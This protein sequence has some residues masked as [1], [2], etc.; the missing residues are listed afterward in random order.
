MIQKKILPVLI[1]FTLFFFSAL[2]AFSQKNTNNSSLIIPMSKIASGF[3]TPPDSMLLSVYWYWISDNIS[4][5]GVIKDLHAMKKEGINRAFIGNIGLSD[6][7]YGKVKIFSDEWWDIMH[8][9]LKTATELNIEIGIFNSPG[10]SQSGGP[11][12]KPDE[13]MRYLTSSRIEAT[14]PLKLDVQLKQAAKE[15][16]D[17]RV[18]AF[19][20]PKEF[21]K[22]I[23]DFNPVISSS[24][25]VLDIKNCMDGD[26]STEIIIPLKS[27]FIL[28]FK[29]IE[30]FTARSITFYPAHRKMKLKGEIQ[31]GENGNFKTIKS[32][33][34]DRSNDALNVGF[35]PYAPAAISIPETSSTM[36]R[37]VFKNVVPYRSGLT[38]INIS[39]SPR[40]EDYAE[41]TLAKMFPTPFPYWGSYEWPVQPD[42]HEKDLVIDPSKVIDISK[43]MNTDGKLKWNVPNGKWII[44]RTGM[45]PTGVHNSPASPEGTGLEVDKMSKKHVAAHFDAFLG[46]IMERIPAEDRKTWKVTVEDSYETGGQNWTDGMIEKFK[47]QF[48]YDPLPYIP[49]FSGLVVG[50][51]DRSDRFLWDLRRFVANE[52]AYQYVAGLREVSHQHGL[53]TWLENYGHW[54]FPSTFLMYG[55]QSDEVAGEFWSE[56]DLGNIENRAASSSAHIYGKRKVS[57]E[58]F[59]AG[60]KA[61]ARYPAVMKQRGD[62]FFTEGIN[63]TLLHLYIEQPYDDKLPGVNAPFGNEFNRNNTWFDDLDL[64]IKY[65]KRC[66]FMLQQGTYIADAAYFIGEDAPKM[67]GTRDPELPKGYSFDYMNAEVIE[68]RMQVKNGRLTL[69]DGMNYGILVLPKLKTMRPEVLKKIMQ[70]VNDGAVVL[71]PK[72]DRSPSLENYPDADKEVKKLAAELWGNID[73]KNIKVHHYGKGMVIDGMNM[74]EALSRIKVSPDYK[75]G[76][77]DSTLFIHR[78]LNGGDIYFISNQTEKAI[79]INP[80]FRVKGKSPELWNA[81]DGSMR[82]LPAYSFDEEG[83]SVPLKLEPLQSVCIVFR[84]GGTD[85]ASKKIIGRS[86]SKIVAYNFPDPIQIKDISDDWLVQFDNVMRGPK[87]PVIFNELTDWTKNENDSI[88]YYSGTAVYTK[89]IQAPKVKRG[90]KVFL[91]LGDLITM[92]KVKVNGIYVGGAWTPPYE[93]DITNA[94]KPGQNTLEI[95]VVNNWMNRLIGDLNLPEAERKTWVSINPYKAGS[96]L[97]ASGLFGPV[98]LKVIKY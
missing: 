51:E 57:A 95:S 1:T 66:N 86:L 65:L 5:E 19:P 13:A 96:P 37:I 28:N 7:P 10:W 47:K 98:V 56:G 89:T 24:P 54:G 80:K 26:T 29:T 14:G 22:N 36:F 42:F 30:P 79:S 52:V 68:K 4:K 62:R 82:N 64:F 21:E 61:F 55:G 45:T 77:D 39:S 35:D 75:T 84:E 73:S 91:D 81:I 16:Q 31:A 2:N 92:A 44:M 23:R 9:A 12:I 70:L 43:Y 41:K 58:S 50:S 33:T 78:K 38:E 67:T 32:F 72:P 71:G 15:F 97:Q 48:G 49:V 76:R 83:T 74:Q 40:L 34:V 11:W 25:A 17:V 18:I 27:G 53:H 87:N 90:E 85:A 3:E 63:N 46:K 59:T 60:G 69:P 8:A 94:L 20:A 88:K 93:V 6:V